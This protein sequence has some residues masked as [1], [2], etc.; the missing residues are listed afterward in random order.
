MFVSY[1]R[2]LIVFLPMLLS[3]YILYT[4]INLHAHA[5]IFFGVL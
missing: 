5:S 4:G 2:E 1:I 3:L